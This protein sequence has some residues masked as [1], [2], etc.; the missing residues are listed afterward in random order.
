[1]TKEQTNRNTITTKNKTIRKEMTDMEKEK[2]IKNKK[3]DMTPADTYTAYT[4]NG[5]ILAQGI[6][7][8]NNTWVTGLNNNDLI[9]G[10]S[11]AGKTRGYVKPNLM[12]ANGSY[13]VADTKGN[14]YHEVGPLLKSKGYDVRLVDFKNTENTCGY[15]PFDYMRFDENRGCYREQDILSVSKVLAP[16]QDQRNVFWDKAAELYLSCLI[17][18]V[19]EQLPEEEHSIE[20]VFKLFCEMNTGTFQELI[21]ELTVLEPDCFAVQQYNMFKDNRTAEKMNESIRGI[22]AEHLNSLIFEDLVHS[23]H[24]PNRINFRELGQ[25]K[26][27]LFLNISDTDRSMDRLVNLFYTQA[28]QVLCDSADNDYEDHRLPVP[29]RFILDDFAA[30]F[31]I[32]DFDNI[33]SVIRSR[34][35]SVSI[36]L[37]SISQLTKMYSPAA[38]TTIINNCDNWLY[39][40]GQDLETAKIIS[41]RANVLQNTI[42]DMPLE[43][44]YLFTRGQKARL[45]Q[46]FDLKSHPEYSSLPEAFS[47]RAKTDSANFDTLPQADAC[48]CYTA[49][50]S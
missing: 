9:I 43:K 1:M 46:K 48:N 20:Y 3:F 30:N 14:L 39:L 33:T 50:I 27:A 40:G 2:N 10:P 6:T 5:R 45:V 31:T 17:S 11:G 41:T 15:N 25:K 49:E 21:N 44:A 38:A 32:P 28:L 36:I 7:L 8:S 13:V 4:D 37:Q 12:Q 35:I 23:Y 26:M 18:Y 29:V 34:E 42:I 24:N 22:L 47:H 16:C 19:L